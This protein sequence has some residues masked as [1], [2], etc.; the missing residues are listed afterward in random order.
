MLWLTLG[1]MSF[2]GVVF[3]VWPFL[4]ENSRNFG[5]VAGAVVFVVVSSAGLYSKLGSPGLQNERLTHGGEQGGDMIDAVESLAGRLEQNPD[6]VAGWRMLGRSYMSLNNYP[7]A[8]AAFERVVELEDGQ[9]AQGLV[10]LGE[11]VLAAEGGQAMPPRATSLFENAL[12]IEPNNQAALFW[13]GLAAGNRGD[14]EVAAD[15]W[16]RLLGTN[17]PADIRDA[18]EQR[19]AEWRGE[20]P[21]PVAAATEQPVPAQAAPEPVPPEDGAIVSASIAL[22][23]AAQS[24]LPPDAI[25]FVIARDPAQPSPPIAVTRRRLAELPAVVQLGDRESMVAGRELSGFEEFELVARVSLSGQPVSQ[26]GDW[27]GSVIV[28]PAESGS[29][30][31]SIDTPVE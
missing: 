29:I 15:R 14:I 7:K 28:K 26:P 3:A 9:S 19:V 23:A 22:S 16:E 1:L 2:A 10:E 24:A 5:V 8:I 6:D 20:E 12:A 31:L 11:A 13:G 17:P 27:F 4:R 21:P 18:I 30:A 25:V